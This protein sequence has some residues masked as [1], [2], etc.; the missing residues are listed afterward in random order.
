MSE[1]KRQD[2]RGLRRL[3]SVP[4]YVGI[5]A[6]V[7][8]LLA[9]IAIIAS[10]LA[11]ERP[12]EFRMK[13]FPAK[14]SDDV[15][16]VVEGY[17]RR[18]SDGARLRY[19]I[20]A[21]RATTFAD[22]HQ[23][24]ENVYLEVYDE[25][26]TSFDRMTALK[27]VYLPQGV[28]EFKV[29]FAGS[30]DLQ[31]GDGLRVRTEQLAYDSSDRSAEAEEELEF[32]RDELRGS[33]RG[34]K[35]K[36]SEEKL[37][38]YDEVKV[39]GFAKAGSEPAESEV[40]SF[41]GTSGW[42]E[43]D[44]KDGVARFLKG[45][46]LSVKPLERGSAA[47]A[48]SEFQGDSA[49]AFFTGKEVSR[50]EVEGS[51]QI[52]QKAPRKGQRWFSMRSDRAAAEIEGEASR[53]ELAGGVQIRT[54]APDS[55]PVFISAGI[56]SFDKGADLYTLRQA[57]R[58]VPDEKAG[59][60]SIESA[61]AAYQ[62]RVGRVD[63]EGG[64]TVLTENETLTARTAV[65]YLDS[66]R[67]LKT[68]AAK[69]D[70]KLAQ[71]AEDRV[72]EVEAAA[73]TAQFEADG[74]LRRAEAGGDASVTVI[75]VSEGAFSR[76]RVS[77]PKSIVAV[78]G[79]RGIFQSVE[80]SG[81][82]AV[83][84]ASAAGAREASDKKVAADE[85]RMSFAPDG[86]SLAKSEAVG[87]AELWISAAKGVPASYSTAVSSARFDCEF[88]ADNEPKGC[89]SGGR[90]KAVR[91]P[92][93]DA[94]PERV[95]TFTSESLEAT[96]LAGG[97][98]LD[99]LQASGSAR[100][101]QGAANGS[102]ETVRYSAPTGI[103]AL[104][105]GQPMVWDPR[106]RARSK[107]ID[108]ETLTQTVSLRG[109]VSTTYFNQTRSKTSAPFSRPDAPVFVTSDSARFFEKDRRAVYTGGARAWQGD[110]YI[111]GD[112]I[113]IKGEARQMSAEGNVRSLLDDAEGSGPVFGSSGRLLYD[114]VSSSVTFEDAVQLSQGTDRIAARKLTA[115]LN[116]KNEIVTAIAEREVRVSQP[117]RRAT[118]DYAQY[119]L[120]AQTVI[121]RGNPATVAEDESGSSE[122]GEVTV[123]LREKRIAGDGRTKPDSS[124]RI[125]SVYKVKNRK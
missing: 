99:V 112:G 107:E 87:R 95:Q 5:G 3:A 93:G 17:E 1:D 58:I 22:A 88:N 102:A 31:T 19:F 51:V 104:R 116:E 61:S 49:T 42:A 43:V 30:V 64:V 77:A 66:D 29:F 33:A 14:L 120:K 18:E 45:V 32:E 2:L 7:M 34:A 53:F 119:D 56:A 11:T 111:R 114:A 27:A 37:E 6:A 46:K 55:T 20:K 113:E 97:G 83:E 25:D 69:G 117:G 86:R 52:E 48:A 67:R 63:A 92:S 28:T 9:G 125:R 36:T 84:V 75:P 74:G 47:G 26:G 89:R 39:S 80:T 94:D 81:R 96:F 50:L 106:T 23:E 115:S 13:T 100:F 38:L 16:A 41:S 15:L 21:D 59:K 12:G 44:R 76:V 57:V 110:N 68:A 73:I 79:G 121:L 103:V 24:L 105:G 122:G 8:L 4:R 91:T 124:G 54:A 62:V 78:F 65:A 10:F 118:G 60:T 101:T 109:S 70:A 40:D 90:A 98:G 82:S 72:S 71:R 123:F 35:L 108:I 85:L